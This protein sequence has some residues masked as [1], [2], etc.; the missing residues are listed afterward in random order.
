VVAKDVEATKVYLV[1]VIKKT[2]PQVE[3]LDSKYL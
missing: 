1:V 2:L 3:A